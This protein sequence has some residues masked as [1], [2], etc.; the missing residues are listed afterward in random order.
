MKRLALF[1]L[2]TL[3]W[4]TV[5]WG[6]TF[7]YTTAGGTSVAF[8]TD[9]TKCLRGQTTAGLKYVGADAGDKW[10]SVR[11]YAQRDGADN[12]SLVVTLYIAPAT[13]AEQLVW[14]D[15][16][17]VTGTAN[18]Y[19]SGTGTAYTMVDG[20]DYVIAV[21]FIDDPNVLLYYDVGSSSDGENTLAKATNPWTAGTTNTNKYSFI[22]Y[23]TPMTYSWGGNKLKHVDSIYGAYMRNDD[24]AEQDFDTLNH[25]VTVSFNFKT[26]SGTGGS[27]SSNRTALMRLVND[28]RTGGYTQDS[29]RIY[30]AVQGTATGFD[31]SL[32]YDWY[33]LNKTW[34]EGT[35]DGVRATSGEV[36][37]D[38]SQT[39]TVA[40]TSQNGAKDAGDHTP[41]SIAGS[42]WIDSTT[43]ARDTLFDNVLYT[44]VTIPS[45]HLTNDFFTK[46]TVF[47]IGEQ[48][49]TTFV[50]VGWGSDDNTVNTPRR[51]PFMV[52][53]ESPPVG[54]TLGIGGN[55]TIGGGV[56]VGGK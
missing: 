41:T 9:T 34:G 42:K 3:A 52:G 39:G 16:V 48:R 8:G 29:V 10:D 20:I 17:V 35:K 33:V 54:G 36:S 49:N 13:A 21:S 5:G 27:T 43:W 50:T 6:A 32:R 11:I 46:G 2:L 24:D 14:R 12:D 44:Y 1:V 23:Y 51:K 38:S 53:W 25:G 37:W 55:T 47:Y 4:P 26:G 31:D 22:G 56:V 45:S 7:G 15:T 28:P 19:S 40:W 30:F 18:W